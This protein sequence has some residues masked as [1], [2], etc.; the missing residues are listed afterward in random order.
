MTKYVLHGGY[1]FHDSPGNAA[2]FSTILQAMPAG[3]E[4]LV[5]AFAQRADHRNLCAQRLEERLQSLALPPLSLVPAAPGVFREQ[6]ES[7]EGVYFCGGSTFQLLGLLRY[8]GWDWVRQTLQTKAL[9]A[10]CSAGAYVLSRRFYECEEAVIAEGMGLIPYDC[11]VHVDTLPPPAW[12]SE[13][14]SDV[15]ALPEHTYTLIECSPS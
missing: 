5:C 14:L 3:G 13:Q 4:L 2:Y 8:C 7:C 10:G 1:E 11:L 12:A 6:L 15:L 9:V